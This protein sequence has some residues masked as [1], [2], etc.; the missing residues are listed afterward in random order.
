MELFCRTDQ[1]CVCQLCDKSEHEGHDVVPLGEECKG[2]KMELAKA[3]VKFDQMIQDRKL[4]IQELIQTVKHSKEAADKEAANGVYVFTA[5][6]Q[7]VE[8]SLAEG[9]E[10]IKLKQ[11]TAAIKAEALVKELDHEISKLMKRSSEVKQILQSD[12][13]LHL[14]NNFAFLNALPPIKDWTKSSPRQ[15][16]YEG[17]MARAAARLKATLN[18]GTEKLLEA[19]LKRVQQ[20]AVDVTLDPKTAHPKLILSDDGKQ[21][22]HSDVQMNLPDNPERFSYRVIVLSEQ[23]F[24]SGRFYYEVEVRGKTKWDLGVASGSADRKGQIAS[25]PEAGYWTLQLRN[26][27]EYIALANPEVVLSVRQRPH[28][29]GVFVDYEEGLI[30]FFDVDTTDIIYSFTGCTFTDKLHP[31]FSPCCNDGGDNSAPLRIS[32]V[33]KM[34]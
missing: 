31:F 28:K 13:P 5:L 4:K 7:S 32:V 8:T 14:I 12:D 1:A 22:N 21:V 9:I 30:S 17:T 10:H 18:K 6:T 33:Q 2:K 11:K 24:S 20:Y 16:S 27:N 15:P 23:S 3:E 34:D 29:M 19:E 25:S 26:G